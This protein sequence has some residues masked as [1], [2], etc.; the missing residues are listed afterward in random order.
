MIEIYIN[1]YRMKEK[2]MLVN[3]LYVIICSRDFD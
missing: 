3:V 2:N 1:N